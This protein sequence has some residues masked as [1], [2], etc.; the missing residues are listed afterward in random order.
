MDLTGP[1]SAGSQ[2]WL[3]TG[4]FCVNSTSREASH[5]IINLMSRRDLEKI[6]TQPFITSDKEG[7]TQGTKRPV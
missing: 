1:D 3:L 2:Q 5:L 7:M 4:D 6:L